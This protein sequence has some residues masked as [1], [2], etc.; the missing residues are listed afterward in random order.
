MLTFGSESGDVL[1]EQVSIHRG[2]AVQLKGSAEKFSALSGTTS[3]FPQVQNLGFVGLQLFFNQKKEKE[4][5]L[6]IINTH[7]QF[8]TQ[9]KSGPQM[10]GKLPH[11]DK[12]LLQNICREENG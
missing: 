7:T 8:Y 2:N 5:N 9:Y 12:L 4:S 11:W 10:G 3:R 6:F 1:H